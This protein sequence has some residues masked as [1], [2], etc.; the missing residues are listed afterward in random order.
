MS[1]MTARLSHGGA[2]RGGHLK[3]RLEHL[4]HDPVTELLLRY[5]KE[6]LVRATH[7]VARLGVEQEVFLF[8]PECVHPRNN[9]PR[10]TL[11]RYC[12]QRKTAAAG[13]RGGRDPYRRVLR[14]FPLAARLAAARS[15]DLLLE[16]LEADRANHNIVADYVA[17]RAIKPER[18]GKLEAFLQG[19]LHFGARNVLVE[20]RHVE[21]DVL[22]DGQGARLVRLA[23]TPEH[24]LVEFEIFLAGLVLHPN[25]DRDLRRLHRARAEHGEFLQDDLEIGVVLEQREHVVHSSLTVT[26]VVVEELDEGDVSVGIAKHDLP[27]RAEQG[28]RILLDRRLVLLVLSSGLPFVEL[29]HRVLKHFR[30]RNQVLADNA[31]DL[32]ALT[33]RELVSV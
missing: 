14:G 23:A 26:A 30:V 13:Y 33:G 4:G 15:V 28:F 8:H 10:G 19:R 27:R 3:L 32:A 2:R 11:F 21:A 18:F 16:R 29:V 17:W 5:Q 12:V 31:L 20:P 1:E 9:R 22:G 25:R 24:L 6:I 7:R